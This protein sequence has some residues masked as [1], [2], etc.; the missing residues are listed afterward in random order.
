MTYSAQAFADPEW[1]RWA[2]TGA[3]LV[4]GLPVLRVIDPAA[5]Q[6][7]SGARV[8]FPGSRILDLLHLLTAGAL[9]PHGRSSRERGEVVGTNEE[10]R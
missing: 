5:D 10:A 2:M 3:H 1:R 9:P 8:A 4:A 6:T 7:D